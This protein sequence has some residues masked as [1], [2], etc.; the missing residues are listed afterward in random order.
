MSISGITI[1]ESSSD[2][3]KQKYLIESYITLVFKYI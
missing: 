3:S 2:I 1:R